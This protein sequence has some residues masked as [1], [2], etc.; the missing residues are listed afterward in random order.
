VAQIQTKVK[1]SKPVFARVTTNSP[2][3]MTTLGNPQ[4]N[5][6]EAEKAGEADQV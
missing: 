1:E 6:K 4:K 5:E 2:A 3:T